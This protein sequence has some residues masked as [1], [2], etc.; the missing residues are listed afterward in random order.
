MLVLLICYM[1][2]V[3]GSSLSATVVHARVTGFHIDYE[4]CSGQLSKTSSRASQ[5]QICQTFLSGLTNLSSTLRRESVGLHGR[6]SLAVD[7]GTWMSCP[8]PGPTC[9]HI[10]FGNKTQSVARHVID[11]AD[12]VQLMDYT[13]EPT[14]VLARAEP[15][16]S[17]ADSIKKENSVVVGL[18]IAPGSESPQWYQTANESQLQMLMATLQPKLE[19]HLSF[20]GFAVFDSRA[21]MQNAASKPRALPN[22]A[23]PTAVWG[24]G[25]SNAVALNESQRAD[26]LSFAKTRRIHTAYVCPHCSNIDLIPIPG[27]E[28]SAAVAKMF[29]DFILLADAQ[30][31]D[32]M[33]DSNGWGNRR[34]WDKIDLEFFRNCTLPEP[35]G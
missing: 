28:G 15:F 18:T 2:V 1:Y 10:T 9:F 8:T 34:T 6:L 21:W 25:R 3:C 13:P 33:L 11:I 7:A 14:Q 5:T 16:L 23:M 35:P 32:L 17:Y 20:R 12:T 29:C 24:M 22:K 19:N 27:I 26:F 31:L 4:L 30:G